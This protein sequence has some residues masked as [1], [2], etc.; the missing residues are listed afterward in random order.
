VRGGP[1]VGT[2][3]LTITGPPVGSLPLDV[4]HVVTGQISLH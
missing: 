1:G 4:E 3:Q 2:L